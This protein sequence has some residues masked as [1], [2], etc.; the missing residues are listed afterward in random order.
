MFRALDV[1]T[2]F[3]AQALRFPSG[4]RVAHTGT[5]PAHLLE[6]YEFEACPFCRKVREMLTT[7]DLDVKVYP[8]PKSGTRFRPEVIA[9]GGKAQFPYLVDPNTDTAIYESDDIL[10]YLA[11]RYGDGTIPL[12]LRLGPWTVGTGSVGALLRLPR[13]MRARPSRAPDQPLELW[14]FEFSPYCRIV[15]EALC[16]LELPYVLRNTGR[17]SSNRPEFLARTGKLQFPYLV[18]PNTGAAMFESA[19]IVAYLQQTYGI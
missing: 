4:I 12:A 13:G 11:D 8:C 15:R 18:D 17:S 5:R 7:L 19:D 10:R 2:A 16:E 9:R 14:G 6:L 1:L 3:T